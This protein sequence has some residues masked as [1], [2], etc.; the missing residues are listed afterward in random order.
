LA[1]EGQ[2]RPRLAH[3]L[4]GADPL[5]LARTL[6]YNGPVPP[7]SWPLLLLA[8]G[9]SFARLPFTL[10]ERLYVAARRRSLV[11]AEAPVFI[12]GHW[13]SGTTHLYNILTRSLRFAFISPF[14]TAL[15]W[16]FLLLGRMLRP[17]LGRALPKHRFIDRMA[18]NPDSPQEDEI[19]LANMQTLSFYHG[20]YFPHRLR[21]NF[22]AGIFLDGAEP[23]AIA[24][25]ER[26]L[27]HFFDKLMIEQPGRRLLV[28]NPVYTARVAQLKRLWPQAKFIHIYRNPYV[29]FQSTRNF[30]RALFRELALQPA[31]IAAPET[32]IE[33]LILESYPRMMRALAEDAVRLP[34]EDFVELRFETF[35]QSP[36]AEIERLYATLQLTGFEQDRPLFQEYLQGTQ[37]YRKNTYA[38]PDDVVHKVGAHWREFIDRWDYAAPI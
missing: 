31:D 14:A 7:S 20:L 4:L 22:E 23:W 1:H 13:R 15:P 9:A 33:A 6:A 16:D 37:S 36:L 38:Y 21:E 5:T 35:E 29:V 27:R 26:R 28:K 8:F 25:W 34:T 17:V 30:Y 3:P 24:C 10:A 11:Q 32:L 18:V 12:V 19:A 2:H